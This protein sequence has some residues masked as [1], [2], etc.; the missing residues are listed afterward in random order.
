MKALVYT[1]TQTT[2]IRN[3]PAP[4]A[5]AGQV[6]IDIAYCGLC[7][8]DMHAWHGHDARRIP[9]LILGH[10]IVGTV[11]EGALKGKRV[12]VNPLMTCGSCEACRSGLEHLCHVRELLGMRVPGGFAEQVAVNESNVTVIADHLTFD[13]AALAEPLACAVHAVRLAEEGNQCNRDQKVIVLGGGAI[14]LLAA[15]VFKHHGY[16][17]IQ[18][19]EVN[20]GRRTLLHSL[21]G[22]TAYD[23]LTTDPGE[24]SAHIILDAVGTGITRKA[25]S[26]LVKPGGQIIH[27]GLQDN[28]DGLDTRRLT[29]QEISFRGTY[30]YQNEDFAQAL[31]LL[32]EGHISGAG[33][34]EIRPLDA[35][36]QAFIDVHEGA[37]P[38]KIILACD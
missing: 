22:M 23:P 3:E 2:E 33:W 9:P 32:T 29:L 1:D 11:K 8:S 35:G 16:T 5:A 12:A 24:S 25:A 7:G 20:E 15:L 26:H 31:S 10:E 28:Q 21:G 13:E 18:I 38:P 27:I 4:L 37:A 17:D 34:A 19:A 6:V 36:V 30:C 14:G